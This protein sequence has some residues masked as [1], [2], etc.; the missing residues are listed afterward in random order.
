MTLR[1][2]TPTTLEQTVDHARI[3]LTVPETAAYLG[4]KSTLAYE[5]A[6][7]GELPVVRVGRLVRIHRPTLD[8][9]LAA[10]ARGEATPLTGKRGC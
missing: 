5:K 9:W 7:R 6:A 8:E 4:I 1:A 2:L 10:E 3:M